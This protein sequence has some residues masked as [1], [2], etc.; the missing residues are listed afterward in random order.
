MSERDYFFDAL[1][2][3]AFEAASGGAIRHLADL[4]YTVRQIGERLTCP[5]PYEKVRKTVWRHLLDT[6]VILTKEP[7]YGKR[8]GKANYAMEH[9]KYG[10]ASF[11][12]VKAEGEETGK[13]VWRER[14]YNERLDGKLAVYLDGKCRACGVSDA[15]ISCDFGVQGVKQPEKLL[16][17]LVA[18]NKKQRE[19]IMGLPW[20]PVIC[21]HRLDGRMQEIIVRLYGEGMY[22]GSCYFVKSGEKIILGG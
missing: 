12:L 17:R 8:N 14:R 13:V 6:N 16:S 18:L 4:G 11:R 22:E 3:V 10:R 2:D 21:Y 9:D 7:G 1:S 15:Y 19:Y 5:T 20:E